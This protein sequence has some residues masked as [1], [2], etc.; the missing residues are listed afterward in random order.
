MSTLGDFT[1]NEDVVLQHIMVQHAKKLDE[2]AILR[3]WGKVVLNEPRLPVPVEQ[4][5]GT[6]PPPPSSGRRDSTSSASS[7]GS[8]VSSVSPSTKKGKG[9]KAKQLRACPFEWCPKVRT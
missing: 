1:F 2:A 7:A 8:A 5:E 4:L 9:S 6:P 3:A